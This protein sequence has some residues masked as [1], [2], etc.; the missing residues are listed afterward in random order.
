MP[1]RRTTTH[2][3]VT[4]QDTNFN[5]HPFFCR[6]TMSKTMATSAHMVDFLGKKGLTLK[7]AT[8]YE[9][10][11]QIFHNELTGT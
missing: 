7:I 11:I 1:A 6:K 3:S 10:G 2:P 5:N 9:P 4:S 8:V